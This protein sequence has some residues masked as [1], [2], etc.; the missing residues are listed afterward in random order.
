MT[1]DHE[2]MEALLAHGAEVDLENVFQMTPLMF[3]AGLSGTGGP[4]PIGDAQATRANK[5]IDILLKAGA[6]IN[7][8]IA[9]SHTHTAVLM[10]YVAGRDQ[11]GRSA[12]MGA[13]DDGSAAIVKH[14]LEGG[15]DPTARDA[16]GKSALDLARAPPPTAETTENKVQRDRLIAGRA[17]VVPILEAALAKAGAGAAATLNR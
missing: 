16:T 13:A 12:L 10:S 1:H 17:A 6:N 9:D 2:A 11:E 8:R 14:L 15:A 4:A 5:S 7:A 3:A